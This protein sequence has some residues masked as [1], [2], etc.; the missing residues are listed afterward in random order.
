MV[1]LDFELRRIHGLRLWE[2]RLQRIDS[3][4]A[5]VVFVSQ[6]RDAAGRYVDPFLLGVFTHRKCHQ[7]LA[8]AHRHIFRE[9]L[10]LSARVKLRD[11]QKYCDAICTRSVAGETTWKSL[12]RELIPSGISIDELNLF[13]GD[14]RRLAHIICP[15]TGSPSHAQW[16]TRQ[17]R[18]NSRTM[19]DNDN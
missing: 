11:F 19:G 3:V 9:W 12:C 16:R 6:L 18:T 4:F 2:E 7:I 8:D 15:S 10:G 5:R 14:A 13:A 17:E 1:R